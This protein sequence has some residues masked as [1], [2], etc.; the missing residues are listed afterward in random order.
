[1]KEEDP[2]FKAEIKV[3]VEEKVSP[4]DQNFQAYMSAPS[5]AVCPLAISSDN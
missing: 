4:A 2:F 3:L 1:M 5:V